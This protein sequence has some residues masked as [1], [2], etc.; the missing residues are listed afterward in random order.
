MQSTSS[1]CTMMSEAQ[2]LV[3]QAT[4]NKEDIA[5]MWSAVIESY[6]RVFNDK[7][8]I[9]GSAHTSILSPLVV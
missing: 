9:P 5:R 8:N 6:F 4:R 1:P 2:N 3:D 7:Q